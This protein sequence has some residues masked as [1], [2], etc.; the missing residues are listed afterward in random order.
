[1]LKHDAAVTINDAT[2]SINDATAYVP[3]SDAD[4]YTFD[5]DGFLLVPGALRPDVWMRAAAAADR[6][7]TEE[8]LADRL[9]P[10]RSLHLIGMIDRDPVFLDLLDHPAT[11][12]YVWNLLGWNIHTHHNHLDI[13]P[14]NQ[15]PERASWNWHQDGYRQNSDVDAEPRPMLAVK[16]GF[17]LS[18]M[19]ATGR[20][21]T[22]VIKGSHRWNTLA[23]RPARPNLPFDEPPGAEEI[24]ARAGDAFIFDRRLWHSRSVNTSTLTRKI[25]FIG[26]THRWIR[27][28]DEVDYQRDASWFGA[29]SPVRQQL[30]GAGLNNANFWGVRPDGWIDQSIPLRAELAGR[31][32]LD[33]HLPYLR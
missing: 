22:K 6:V 12:R 3:I 1:V 13:H 24:V 18:D 21:A 25:V 33:G 20:G 19:S 29:L 26:Y 32:L 14:G 15:P 28:L 27:P 4:R 17:V 10:D 11:F 8:L 23:G 16:V 2:A 30:L 7:Y 31:D 5:R 9:R